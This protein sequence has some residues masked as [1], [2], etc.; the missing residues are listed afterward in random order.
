LYE[1][2]EQVISGD[3]L[4]A[5]PAWSPQ[6]MNQLLSAEILASVPEERYRF[7]LGLVQNL[8][9]S[10]KANRWNQTAVADFESISKTALFSAVGQQ[11]LAWFV[12]HHEAYQD[13][14]RATIEGRALAYITRRKDLIARWVPGLRLALDPFAEVG[15]SLHLVTRGN[16]FSG[17]WYLAPRSD[18]ESPIVVIDEFERLPARCWQRTGVPDDAQVGS[19]LAEEIARLLGRD[20]LQS[21]RLRY[22]RPFLGSRSVVD[23]LVFAEAAPWAEDLSLA[24]VHKEIGHLYSGSFTREELEHGIRTWSAY[25]YAHREV[26]RRKE[27]RGEAEV[28]VREGI[29]TVGLQFSNADREEMRSVADG[30]L[31]SGK[32]V[33]LPTVTGGVPRVRLLVALLQQTDSTVFSSPLPAQ[34]T[35]PEDGGLIEDCYSPELKRAFLQPFFETAVRTLRES[36]ES[37]LGPVVRQHRP[38]LRGPLAVAW[39][40]ESS[41]SAPDGSVV[42]YVIGASEESGDMVVESSALPEAP[43]RQKN[44]QEDGGITSKPEL[45]AETAFSSFLRSERRR[46]EGGRSAPTP[47]FDWTL[48]ELRGMFPKDLFL[49]IFHKP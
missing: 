35:A 36:T 45:W 6:A 23:E 44:S 40:V 27:E 1:T 47:L 41:W 15:A 29:R 31:S 14:V 38:W 42:T 28:V 2:R 22:N 34:D 12:S 3:R 20:L 21:S 43:W 9:V 10:I 26:A 13:V 37:L 32:P 46:S 4:L 33:P 7:A 30:I 48:R 5:L 18:P 39:H 19:D 49:D 11:A 8:F 17:L 25:W 16:E 24:G